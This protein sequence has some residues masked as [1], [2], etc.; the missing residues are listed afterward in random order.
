MLCSRFNIFVNFSK[1]YTFF[2]LNISAEKLSDSEENIDDVILI[3]IIATIV[4]GCSGYSV[5]LFYVNEVSISSSS[6][7]D[8]K[9]PE[10]TQNEDKN[11]QYLK[12]K[13]KKKK[14]KRAI[15]SSFSSE[16]VLVISDLYQNKIL[17]PNLSFIH[18]ISN[19][20]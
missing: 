18:T 2:F 15:Q 9:I 19:C 11:N 5:S 1:F 14:K 7:N 20:T 10:H 8:D 17:I 3:L 4:I 13:K 16:E 6:S 12:K